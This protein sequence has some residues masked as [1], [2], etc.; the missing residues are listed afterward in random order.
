MVINRIASHYLDNVPEVDVALLLPHPGD[1]E[2]Y[3]GGTVAKLARAGKRVAILDLTA[4]EA[5]SFSRGEIKLDEADLAAAA[6]G[7]L[8]RGSIRFPDGRLE[9]TIM[10]RMTVTGEVKRLRAN[11][12]VAMHPQ[13]PHP[14]SLAASLLV[15]NACYL[16]GLT[17]LDDYLAAHR[18]ERI[19][20]A[21]GPASAAP[22]FVVDITDHFEQ[23]I[24][25][26]RAYTTL[27]A[28]ADAEIARVE[29]EALR[30]GELVGVRYGEAF[31]QRQPLRGDLL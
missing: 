17:K 29:R 18:P 14:D 13:H 10:S 4:G 28:D 22:S 5:G 23:K 19:V 6:L 27:F 31:V 20:F 2:Y 15:E 3:C 7:V 11:I 1:A 25:A 16:A 9:D 24:A 21:G 12:V 30:I 8:W 26:L